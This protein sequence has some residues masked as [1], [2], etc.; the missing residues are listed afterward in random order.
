MTLERGEVPR[1]CV[2]ELPDTAACGG[3]S[4]M[5]DIGQ[6]WRPILFAKMGDE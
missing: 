1:A 6:P 5:P 4:L 2:S 3:S